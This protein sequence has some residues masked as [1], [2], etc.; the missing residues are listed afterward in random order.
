[1]LHFAD[2]FPVRHFFEAFFAAYVPGTT[3]PGFDWGHLAVV[4]VWGVA[5][6]LLAIRFFRWTPARRLA[7]PSASPV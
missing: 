3:A 7:T 4:A 5:G 2:A 1:M 6:L